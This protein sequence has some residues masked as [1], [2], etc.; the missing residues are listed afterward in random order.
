MIRLI[1]IIL[2][3]IF[4][5]GCTWIARDYYYGDNNNQA[6]WN[7]QF[8]KGKPSNK[9]GTHPAKDVLTYSYKEFELKLHISYQDMTV[10]GPVIIP[11]IPTLWD[12]TNTLTIQVEID[13]KEKLITLD[14]RKW[15]V[16]DLSTKKVYYPSSINLYTNKQHEF[17]NVNSIHSL[18]I[19]NSAKLYIHYQINVSDTDEIEIDIGSFSHEKERLTPSPIK[20]KKVKGDW[21]F[22]Q[23]SV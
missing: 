12:T 15:L 1:N 20:L 9:Q 21:H 3:L 7:H 18:K 6:D 11:I 19:Y 22:N 14:P 10:Y 17:M 13:S 4:F 23:W 5:N 16:K 2:I 8:T